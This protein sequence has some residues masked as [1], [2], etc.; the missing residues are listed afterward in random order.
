MN[1]C[2][3]RMNGLETDVARRG[4]E[5]FLF[6]RGGGAGERIWPSPSSISGEGRDKDRYAEEK[7]SAPL[8]LPDTRKGEG[9]SPPRHPERKKDLSI[10]VMDEH[11]REGKKSS[12][13]CHRRRR[14]EEEVPHHLAKKGGAYFVACERGGRRKNRLYLQPLGKKR[15]KRVRD[16]G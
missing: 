8:A 7:K 6:G 5:S 4:K 10:R 13:R 2:A 1:P 15:S 16:F 11:A 12:D 3:A 9:P 14:E